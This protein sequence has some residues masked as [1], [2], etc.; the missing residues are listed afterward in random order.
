M[1]YIQESV[2]V[3]ADKKKWNLELKREIRFAKEEHKSNFE[4]DMKA[5]E[6]DIE[7]WREVHS[8]I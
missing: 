8:K 7:A 1:F 4:R 2:N 5:Y 6:E 3:A